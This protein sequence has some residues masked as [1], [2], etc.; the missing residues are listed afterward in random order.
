M[1][2]DNCNLR[3]MLVDHCSHLYGNP[4]TAI[5]LGIVDSWD[6]AYQHNMLTGGSGMVVHTRLCY[7]EKPCLRGWWWGVN[8]NSTRSRVLHVNTVL[9][10]SRFTVRSPISH[11]S[12]LR[13]LPDNFKCTYSQLTYAFGRSRDKGYSYLVLFIR[14][15][16]EGE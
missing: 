2:S 5:G 14:H 3:V 1:I 15:H 11:S 7:T 10:S 9:P 12:P 16:K 13:T 8:S 6:F 4:V